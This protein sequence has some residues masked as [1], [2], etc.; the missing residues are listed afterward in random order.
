MFL[1]IQHSD[2]ATQEK[3]LPILKK[4]V[5]EKKAHPGDLALLID[6]LSIAKFG[7]QIY[8]SQ[9]HEDSISKKQVFFPIKNEK[10]VDKLR[11]K[12]KLQPLAEYGKLFEI[13]YQ[14]KNEE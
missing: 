8:G 13:D 9:V 4:A 7:Y 3:Y 5:K 1:I 11:K 6:R 14:P 10:N 12:M 2:S